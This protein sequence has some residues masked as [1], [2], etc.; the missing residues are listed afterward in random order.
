MHNEAANGQLWPDMYYTSPEICIGCEFAFEPNLRCEYR[1]MMSKI[2]EGEATLKLG[3][4][5]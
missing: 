2:Y 4:E 5:H 1:H 3:I